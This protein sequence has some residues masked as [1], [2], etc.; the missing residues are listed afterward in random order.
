[1]EYSLWYPKGQEFTLREFTD[2]NWEGSV[3][4]RKSTNGSKF[5]LGD[6]LISWLSKKQSSIA[7]STTKAE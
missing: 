6:Y 2:A 1:M 4:D 5:Y 7:L 3:D